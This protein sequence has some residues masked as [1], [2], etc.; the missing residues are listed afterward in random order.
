MVSPWFQ[1][2][3]QSARSF[4]VETDLVAG[5]PHTADRRLLI[6]AG[7]R[8]ASH[9]PAIAS[10]DDHGVIPRRATVRTDNAK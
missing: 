10:Q 3:I 2:K 7:A 5:D 9:V 4:H 6:D 8:T 1:L